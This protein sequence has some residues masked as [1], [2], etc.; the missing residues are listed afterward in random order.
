[1]ITTDATSN[2]K[3]P[4]VKSVK[5]YVD[6]S[7]T[8]SSTALTTEVRRATNAENTITTNLSTETTDRTN[9]D[10]GITSNLNNEATR[11][12]AAEGTKVNVSDTAAML[13]PYAKVSHSISGTGTNNFLPKFSGTTALGNSLIFD[14]G[15]NIGVGTATPSSL[16]Q[17]GGETSTDLNMKYD[18]IPNTSSALKFGYRGYQ[19]RFKTGT[20]SGALTGMVISYF[21]GTNDVDKL[22]INP[23][24]VEVAN[25]LN[26]AGNISAVAATLNSLDVN[27]GQFVVDKVNSRIGLFTENPTSMFQVGGDGNADFNLKF[28]NSAGNGGTLKLGFRQYQWRFKTSQNSGVL[29]PLVLSYFNGTTD[30]DMLTIG[31]TG[32]IT[33]S[34]FIKSGGTSSQFLKADGSVDANTYLTSGSVSST[35]L[36]LAGGTLTGA[37]TGTDATF[38]KDITAN[39][40]KVGIGAGA[41]TSN[42]AI[43]NANF[44]ANTTGYY[45]LAIGQNAMFNNQTGNSNTIVGNGALYYNTSS[46]NI[47]ALGWHALHA[48]Q[49]GGNTAIGYGA[50]A[51]GGIASTLTNSTFLGNN[52][53]A[54][55]GTIDNATAIGSGANV[56]NSRFNWVMA[57]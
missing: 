6:A 47:T 9:A 56:S 49:G 16:F 24:S 39:T 21:D 17:I 20:S 33:A 48:E 11:A 41:V 36:P 28:D 31:Y 52:A 25:N 26:V 55:G 46:S 5:D 22:T 53:S 18:F 37:L 10:A 51:R 19:W 4:S 3:Y 13:S 57:V 15:T 7:S 32:G 40:I 45:N 14:N 54:G 44:T 23:S 42:L 2:T 35:Y 50:G 8:G 29:M 27:G 12:T 43:G 38:S 1:D 34:S 30:V